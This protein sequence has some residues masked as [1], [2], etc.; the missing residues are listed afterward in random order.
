MRGFSKGMRQ[1]VLLAAA[2]LHRPDGLVLDE[3]FSGLDV[4][5]ALLFRALSRPS[6][7]ISHIRAGERK[8]EIVAEFQQA[9][10]HMKVQDALYY[11][12]SSRPGVKNLLNRK[13]EKSTTPV[14]NYLFTWEYPINGG[15]TAFHC[16]EIALQFHALNVPQIHTATGGGPEAMA[17]QDTV[18]QAWINFAKT[19]NPSHPGLEWKPYTTTDPQAMIFDTNSQSRALRDDNLVSLITEP[20]GS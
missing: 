6:R 18:S 1:R 14:Y 2:L 11:A 7:T 13:L 10:P 12:A 17:L 9:F 19:G 3:P 15:I 5:A 4:G 8:N 16:S 20:S